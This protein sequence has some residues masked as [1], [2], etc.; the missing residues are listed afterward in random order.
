MA[1]TRTRS[2]TRTSRREDTQAAAQVTDETQADRR[3]L[4]KQAAYHL[5]A[6]LGAIAIWAALDSWYLLTGLPIATGLAVVA[7]VAAGMGLSHL[8]HEWGH[9]LGARLTGAAS[10]VKDQPT[11]LMFD[12]DYTN[13]SADQFMSSSIAGSLGNWLLVLVVAGTI[14]LDSP[15]RTMLLATTVGMAVY[16]AV[17]EWPVIALARRDRDALAAMTEGFGRPGLFTRATVVGILTTLLLWLIL[18]P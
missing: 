3:R 11:F 12:F 13:N 1:E 14:P 9:F 2:K 10:P 8:A 16:V 7:A 15:G 18:L 6:A 17:L 4:L 5:A